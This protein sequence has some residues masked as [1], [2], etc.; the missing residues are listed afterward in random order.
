MPLLSYK[1]RA[2]ARGGGLLAVIMTAFITTTILTGMFSRAAITDPMQGFNIAF[3]NS[4]AAVIQWQNSMT[5]PPPP[6]TSLNTALE[7]KK[8]SEASWMATPWPQTNTN[9]YELYGLEPD[10]AYD[11]RIAHQWSDG[12]SQGQTEW[13]ATS[14]T[15]TQQQIIHISTCD[16][17]QAIG[18]NRQTFD[19]LVSGVIDFG[20][21]SARY[22]LDQDIDCAESANWVWMSEVPQYSL[23]GFWPIGIFTFNNARLT[24]FSG[25]LDGQ[26]HAIRNLAFRAD[27]DSYLQLILSSEPKGIFGRLNRA[28]IKD[29]KLEAVSGYTANSLSMADSGSSNPNKRSIGLLAGA[30]IDSHIE[31]VSVSGTIQSIGPGPFPSGPPYRVTQGDSLSED[32]FRSETMVTGSGGNTYVLEDNYQPN[33]GNSQSDNPLIRMLDNNGNM[34][35]QWQINNPSGDQ[36][37]VSDIAVDNLQRLLVSVANAGGNSGGAIQRYDALTGQY[38]D[39]MPGIPDS[40]STSIAVQ[41]N[42]IYS[43]EYSL[44]TGDISVFRRD[45]DGSNPISWAVDQPAN[46]WQK[47]DPGIL[48]TDHLGH[49]FYMNIQGRTITRYA[50]DGSN[51]LTFNTSSSRPIAMT[52]NATGKVYVS[53]FASPFMQRFDNDGSNPQ[54]WAEPLWGESSVS[55]DG[56]YAGFSAVL[57]LAPAGD[58]LKLMY[59][60]IF[61]NRSYVQAAG[62]MQLDTNGV[63]VSDWRNRNNA[64]S[65]P[66]FVGGLVGVAYGTTISKVSSSA[67]ISLAP[68][69]YEAI[70]AG[71]L[72]GALP[73]SLMESASDPEAV[74]HTITN[75]YFDGSINYTNGLVIAGG[76]VGREGAV[77]G[78]QY[79]IF[80]NNL[81]IQ[82]SYSAGSITAQ[83]PARLLAAGGI[84]SGIAVLN[85]DNSIRNLFSA[86]TITGQAVQPNDKLRYYPHST[87]VVFPGLKLGVG[88]LFGYM[89]RQEPGLSPTAIANNFV[90]KQQSAQS[91]CSEHEAL[92]VYNFESQE[93]DVIDPGSWDPDTIAD[94]P[95][96]STV[97]A[98][99]NQAGEAADYFKF[100]LHN[101]PL[102]NWDFTGTWRTNN[103]ALPTL[104]LNTPP[105]PPQDLGGDPAPTTISLSWQP[106]AD[107]GG[108]PIVDYTIQ[109][110]QAGGS[111]WQTFVHNPSPT[112]SYQISGLQPG[113]SYEFQVAALNAIGPSGFVLGA[114]IT[115]S[116]SPAGPS[117]PSNPSN[118]T[119]P[120]SP[121]APTNPTYPGNPNTPSR[122]SANPQTPSNPAPPSVP[123]ESSIPNGLDRA[124]RQPSDR[125]PG[126]SSSQP[127]VVPQPAWFDRLSPLLFVSLLLLMALLYWYMAYRDRRQHKQAQALL[128]RY[129]KT[130]QNSSDFLNISSHYLR[131]PLAIMSGAVELFTA[132]QVLAGSVL[133]ELNRQLTA[134]DEVITTTQKRQ[135]ESLSTSQPAG[136]ALISPSSPDQALLTRLAASRRIWIPL[137]T[138]A[139]VVATVDLGLIISGSY[140]IALFRDINMAAFAMLAVAGIGL[141]AYLRS[142]QQDINKQQAEVSAQQRS[143]MEQ[144]S[145]LL[146][147][148]ATDIDRAA[149]KLQSSSD[150]FRQLQGTNLFFNGLAMLTDLTTALKRAAQFSTVNGVP[151][152]QQ[153]EDLV[154][155]AMQQIMPQA[156]AKNISIDM[157]L[158]PSLGIC[159]DPVEA[160]FMVSSLLDNAVKFSPEASTVRITSQAKAG[161]ILITITDTGPG[162]AK[163]K[164]KDLFQPFA[165]GSSTETYDHQGIGLGLYV[166]KIAVEK[167]GGRLI[168]KNS[169]PVGLQASLSLPKP[170]GRA[171]GITGSIVR[172]TE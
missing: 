166:T 88:G 17:L 158:A 137:A 160:R 28:T 115:T 128:S 108:R 2:L 129:Q 12:T 7:Y 161:Q 124:G 80:G 9:S 156:Q 73:A 67:Q 49:V 52:V 4:N 74:T 120:V 62:V 98:S 119:N 93:Y 48:A 34:V 89:L 122:P 19:P 55:S 54:N 20:D 139:T 66:Y 164:L 126:L 169:S 105:S 107:N 116:G 131:T 91:K 14:A 153:V 21:T 5:T 106:P 50:S 69:P 44:I 148:V 36:L 159:A 123:S 141:I 110:R 101:P 10:T 75:S 64:N 167:L 83:S 11:F 135:A 92:N 157:Q 170:V 68:S 24:A 143:L 81:V 125:L 85:N 163:D 149:S 33:I 144:K 134:L 65:M 47:K 99:V 136:S 118:P 142:K 104:G 146:G 78:A 94:T 42:Y 87:S 82:N 58:D 152:L 63:K 114:T 155:D 3:I 145:Q 121:A 46:S 18:F 8:Q 111:D 90:D 40:I 51:A 79:D 56:S 168:L 15:T 165:R 77:L 140:R 27:D 30:A 172:P 53:A 43:V 72:V 151:P 84:A 95:P 112:T 25:E 162:I 113:V 59:S 76:L 71:G 38:I 147:G 97:C 31:G 29:L 37:Q 133:G 102:D 45:S 61:N 103:N 41:G 150:E 13:A 35:H 154:T 6:F 130:T 132:K 86:T 57:G 1:W 60:G 100:N 96:P 32:N 16:Q 171:I 117:S 39:S 70:V 109:Y 26:G 22:V 138:T 23:R 127:V